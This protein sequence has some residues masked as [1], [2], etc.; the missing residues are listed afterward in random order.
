VIVWYR[1]RMGVPVGKSAFHNDFTPFAARDQLRT[2][3]V[4]RQIDETD[5]P[6]A[7][8]P[9]V[10]SYCG[11]VSVAVSRNAG[12]PVGSP[13][14]NEQILNPSSL[15]HPTKR[16]PRLSSSAPVLLRR[17][18]LRQPPSFQSA[19]QKY[20]APPEFQALAAKTGEHPEKL[21]GSS[22]GS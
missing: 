21:V 15:Q 20:R 11:G 17:G 5:A 2:G 4:G 8:R 16:G 13:R 6:G 9:I 7:E 14:E 1:Q 22:S 18:G 3:F 12:R 10:G 19:N